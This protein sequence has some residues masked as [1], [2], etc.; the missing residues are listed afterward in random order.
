MVMGS[1]PIMFATIIEHTPIWLAFALASPAFWAIVHVLD[2]YCVDRI[3]DK[4]WMGLITS[5]LCTLAILPA[6]WMILLLQG[7][8]PTSTIVIFQC[9]ACGLLF[10]ASQRLYFQALSITE[11]GIV[12]AYWNFIP[13]LLP[14]AS[15][16][17]WGE[18]LTWRQAAGSAVLVT[19]SV[20]FCLLDGNMQSRW[21][22]FGMMFL[23]ALLQVAYFLIQKDLLKSCPAFQGFVLISSFIALI[24][25][26][27]LVAAPIRRSLVSNWKTI[28]PVTG[29]LLAIEAANL[30]AIA[31]SHY[32]VNHGIPSLVAAVES[33]IPGYTFVFSF[34]LYAMTGKIG[35]QEAREHLTWKL[36][37]VLLLAWGVWLVS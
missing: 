16:F 1:S 35:E 33:T 3:F 25:T 32:A 34:L 22:A 11:S 29:L 26:L 8:E 36:S 19:G 15:Y 5:G 6:L 10:V 4:P 30:T 13:L 28:R 7:I 20:A 37:L 31:T 12:A 23:G 2:A 18:W 24:A 9:L 27:P 14:V 17:L 21:S